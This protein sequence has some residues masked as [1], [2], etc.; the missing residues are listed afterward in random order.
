[1]RNLHEVLFKISEERDHM[2][3]LVVD[4][5]NIKTDREEA[6]FDGVG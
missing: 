5:G 6:G 2:E 4:G 3:N 1:V